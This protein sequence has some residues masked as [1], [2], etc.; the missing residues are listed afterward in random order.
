MPRYIDAPSVATFK[1]SGPNPK[2]Q[3][4]I[5]QMFAAGASLD[6]VKAKFHDIEPAAIE[7]WERSLKPKPAAA[8]QPDPDPE[9][10]G[11]ADEDLSE[12]EL[13]AEIDREPEARR[14]G[15]GRRKG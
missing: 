14:G 7:A 10:A 4:V 5:R 1:R 11:D 3:L 8:P 15:R 2:E 12:A 13:Q 6:E 9:P